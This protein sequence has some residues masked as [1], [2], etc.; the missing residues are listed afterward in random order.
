M[1]GL[2]ISLDCHSSVMELLHTAQYQRVQGI[3]G[4]SRNC[5]AVVVS[6]Q[7]GGKLTV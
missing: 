3:C 1:F 6:R 7:G 4:A 2:L 5:L